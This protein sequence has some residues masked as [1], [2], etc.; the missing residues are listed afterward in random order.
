MAAQ[1]ARASAAS[2]YPQYSLPSPQSSEKSDS[3]I[4]DCISMP[5]PVISRASIPRSHTAHTGFAASES[6]KPELSLPELLDRLSNRSLNTLTELCRL[7]RI[8]MSYGIGEH[9][10]TLQ[11]P[12]ALAWIHH[13]TSNQLLSELRGL[14]KKYP[15]SADLL[16]EAHL[17]VRADSNNNSSWNLAWLCLTNI[18]DHGLVA[19]YAALEARRPEMWAGFRPS[20]DEV[21]QLKACFEVEWNMALDVMLRHWQ[22]PPTWY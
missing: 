15:F 10:S 19:M 21:A 22:H 9:S 12:L 6:S 5:S 8:A 14:T 16:H 4:F 3:E 18:R 11:K 1:T 20:A 13:V 7:E 2:S 17:R